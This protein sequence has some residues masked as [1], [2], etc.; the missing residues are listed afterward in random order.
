MTT[1]STNSRGTAAT[2]GLDTIGTDIY[3]RA[4]QTTAARRPQRSRQAVMPRRALAP[5][6]VF[7][8]IGIA[9][10]SLG[11]GQSVSALHR[12][13]SIGVDSDQVLKV[14]S[15]AAQNPGVSNAAL[16]NTD[17]KPIAVNPVTARRD[18][19]DH[20]QDG[21]FRRRGA[22]SEVEPVVCVRRVCNGKE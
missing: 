19:V 3:P 6:T 14:Q 4:T 21:A 2:A 13:V 7:A 1:L 22:E 11:F 20:I 16:V 18:A 9:L 17:S 15:D 12:A 5:A 8:S 10:A